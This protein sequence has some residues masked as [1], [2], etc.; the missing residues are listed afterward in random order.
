MIQEPL[1]Y[2]AA[3]IAVLLTG[4]SKGGFGGGLGSLSVPIIALVISPIE[5]AAIML[6]LLIAM[7][8]VAL[9]S[10]RGSWHRQNIMILLP[11][12][13]IGITIGAFTFS[14]F[15]E[16]AI[17]ILI[18]LIAIVF[19]ANAILKR[20]PQEPTKPNVIKGTFWGIIS[21]FTSFGIHSGGP[22]ASVY[23]LPQRMEKKLLMGTMAIT[24]SIINLVKLIPY[25]A[26]GQFNTS[27]LLT[28]LI[29]LPFAPIGVRLGYFLLHKVN[30][31][32]IYQICY[33]GLGVIG[34]KL[35]WNGITGALA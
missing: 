26:L 10:F 31:K 8:I 23:M 30:E 24:F 15:S 21:G 20:G 29:L 16:D 3:I 13:V 22:P 7:D 33:V 11:G 34:L 5:A 6:P 14:Y 28:S 18:G 2:V 1:F 19:C 17:R 27:N 4:M 25:A 9:W 12:A 32:V 35:L